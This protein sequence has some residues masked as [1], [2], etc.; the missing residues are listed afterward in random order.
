M[1]EE[2]VLK[3]NENFVKLKV[4]TL[5][6]NPESVKEFLGINRFYMLNPT[7]SHFH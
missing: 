6:Q 5:N 7:L 2:L 3:K 1:T 4:E